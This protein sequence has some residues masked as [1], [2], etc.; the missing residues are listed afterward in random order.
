MIQLGL[1][2]ALY[3]VVAW[4][5]PDPPIPEYGIELSFGLEEQ[6]ATP[7]PA[8]PVEETTE[9]PVE[10]PV[11]ETVESETADETPEDVIDETIEDTPEEATDDPVETVDSDTPVQQPEEQAKTT[12]QPP[13]QTNPVE[14][15]KPK[16]EEKPAQTETSQETKE[17][18]EKGNTDTAGNQ[19]D[20]EST[21]DERALYGKKGSGDLDGA[22]LQMTG[23]SWDQ[24]PDPK[25]SSDETGKIVFQI[26]IDQDGY[27][28]DLKTLT[29]TVTPQVEQTY[30]RSIEKLTFSQ[31]S[32]YQPA[33]FS[34]GTI[35][36]IIKSK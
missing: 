30:R 14:E 2:A 11:E 8:T 15:T 35:T 33:P 21:I 34:T 32:D 20:P 23:W 12:E 10:N 18:T 9:D 24:E 31:T 25:D 4:R 7:R 13:Q 27:I 29:S 36:F 3:F 26:K 22:S 19:G 5:E 28:I 6:G 1:F 17:N 16:E